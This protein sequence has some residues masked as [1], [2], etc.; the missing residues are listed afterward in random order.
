MFLD[1]VDFFVKHYE[2]LHDMTFGLVLAE[3]RSKKTVIGII[4]NQTNKNEDWYLL[5][6]FK[7]FIYHQILQSYHYSSEEN[8]RHRKAKYRFNLSYYHRVILVQ[9]TSIF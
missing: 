2:I 5:T 9:C 8:S 1:K 7:A 3:L 4:Y 6:S